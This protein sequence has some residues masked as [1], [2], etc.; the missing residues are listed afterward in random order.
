AVAGLEVAHRSTRRRG[1]ESGAAHRQIAVAGRRVLGGLHAV[2]VV[3]ELDAA[4]AGRREPGGLT[5]VDR[6]AGVAC[7]AAVGVGGHP[8]RARDAAADRLRLAVRHGGAAIAE[9][10][11]VGVGIKCRAG[12]ARA[13]RRGRARLLALQLARAGRVA[14][15]RVR[16]TG[17]RIVRRRDH[18]AVA[19]L[20]GD[21]ARAAAVGAS[22]LAADAVLARQPGGALTGGGAGR[23]GHPFRLAGSALTDGAGGAIEVARAAHR[24]DAARGA[25]VDAAG[26]GDARGAS[27]RAVA[28]GGAGLGGGGGAVRAGRAPADR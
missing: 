22:A 27:A 6:L 15:A 14:G 1:G 24:A 3:V 20:A 17:T 21:V 26:G 23:G 7:V 18:H 2:A 4:R 13:V 10:V 12:A 25:Q 9:G 16:R 11:A 28:T 5:G 8:A 19:R